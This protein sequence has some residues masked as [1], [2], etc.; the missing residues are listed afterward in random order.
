MLEFENSR[1]KSTQKKTVIQNFMD[2]YAAFYISAKNKREIKNLADEIMKTGI[3][4]K[5]AY[6]VSCAILGHCKYFITTDDRLLKV[7]I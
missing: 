3:K 5:D 1:N 2:D 6:H 7:P 4:E